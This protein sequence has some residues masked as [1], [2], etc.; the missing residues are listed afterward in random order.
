GRLPYT[1]H[2]PSLADL[3]RAIQEREPTRLGAIDPALRGDVETIVAVALAKEPLRRYASAAQM[4]ADLRR[5]LRDEPILARAPGPLERSRKF[6]RRNRALVAGTAAAFAALAIGTV[7]SLEQAAEARHASRTSDRLAYR[8]SLAAA[9]SALRSHQ[10]AQARRLLDESPARLRGFEWAHLRSRLDES[11]ARVDLPGDLP[12]LLAWRPDGST[13]AIA[14][15]KRLRLVAADGSRETASRELPFDRWR[16]ASSLAFTRDGARLLVGGIFPDGVDPFVTVRD[17]VTLDEIERMPAPGNSSAFD[18]SADRVACTFEDHLRVVDLGDRRVIRDVAWPVDNKV[19]SIAYSAAADA[20]ALSMQDAGGLDVRRAGDGSLLWRFQGGV[21]SIA[22]DRKGTRLLAGL[23]DPRALLVD[24]AN[25]RVLTTFAGHE[26][27]IADAAFS[28]DETSAATVS[29]DGTVRLWD[30]ASGAGRAVF[31][32]HEGR[33]RAV[34]FSPDGERLATVADDSTVRFWDARSRGDANVLPHPHTVYAVAFTPDGRRFVTGCL[35]G[36]GTLRVFDSATGELVAA[37]LDHP[38]TSLAIGADGRELLVGATQ[39]E[40]RRIDAATG[41]RLSTAPYHDW[42]TEALAFDPARP[43]WASTGRDGTLRVVDSATGSLVRS[44]G[45]GGS[46]ARA[47]RRAIYA[48]D[49]SVLFATALSG[50]IEIL[51][52]ESL[53]TRGELTGHAAGVTALALDAQGTRL[54]S[55]AADGEVRLWDVATRRC[56]A[57]L[58]GHEQETFALAFSPDGTRLASGGR[59]RT[60]RIW[61]LDSFEELLLLRGH[62]SFVYALAFS[63]D[64]AQL[65]SGGGDDTAR[66]WSVRPLADVVRARAAR[67]AALPAARAHVEALWRELGSAK[68]VV[69]R[70]RNERDPELSLQVALGRA[71]GGAQ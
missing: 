10:I 6:V 27:G 19:A 62:T 33:M 15:E 34:R 58:R 44:V 21:N 70:L 71:V 47:S 25:G 8:T 39:V 36:A 61:D 17:A 57:V 48:P 12:H 53:E 42:T 56:V 26:A 2:G 23:Y 9:A 24:A 52:G 4:G 5:V 29:N 31:H 68:A 55:G 20:F 37:W 28:P 40:T 67:E 14:G 49:G 16:L 46:P 32:G 51:D 60:I 3:A 41:E 65:V 66:I 7:V 64:G 59:D 63:P 22:F 54:A 13:L 38:V 18:E 50:P 11:L 43:R 30:V 69:E 1:L 45:L 35:G